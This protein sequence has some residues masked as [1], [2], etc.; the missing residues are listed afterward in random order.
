MP[1][2][3]SGDYSPH[4]DTYVQLIHDDNVL[5]ILEEQLSSSLKFFKSVP[6]AK[7]NYS[8]AEG[9]W[10]VKEVLGHIIDTER[11]FAYRALCFARGEEQPL[12]GFEQ[13][14]YMLAANFSKRKF[15]DLIEEFQKVRE[16][17]ILMFKGFDETAIDRRG[18]ASGNP[19][20]VNALMFIIAGH[21]KHH[22]NILKSKYFN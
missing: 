8:Y 6:A 10:S 1:R 3:K 19:I 13:D 18:I 12:P 15:S 5:K 7:E 22:V 17:N 9:K 4:Y 20:T 2:P 14:D 21:E 11:V 16:A